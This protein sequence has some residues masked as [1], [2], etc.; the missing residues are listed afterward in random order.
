MYAQDTSIKHTILYP[1]LS[2]GGWGAGGFWYQGFFNKSTDDKPLRRNIATAWLNYIQLLNRTPNRLEL[3]GSSP[4]GFAA[5]AGRSHDENKIQI[6]LNNYQL[7]RGIP[8]EI[9][10]ELV[11]ISTLEFV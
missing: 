5:L 11:G 4:D 3:T 9:T 2:Y 1:G 6:F 10:S 8:Q 7:N